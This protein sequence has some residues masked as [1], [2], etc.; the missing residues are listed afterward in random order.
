[1]TKLTKF[2]QEEAKG[3][4]VVYPYFNS[5]FAKIHLGKL[6]LIKSGLSIRCF[7]LR[8]DNEIKEI[9]FF[10]AEELVENYTDQYINGELKNIY[11]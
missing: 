9:T 2:I 11:P 10:S 1:M 5:K 4:E 7:L 6:I 8:D 3:N